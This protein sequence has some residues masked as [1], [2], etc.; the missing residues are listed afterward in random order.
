MITYTCYIDGSYIS[1]INNKIGYSYLI[2]KDGLIIDIMVDSFISQVKLN[3]S[4]AEL[5]GLLFSM[6]NIFQNYCNYKIKVF[7]DSKY[8]VDVFNNYKNAHVYLETWKYIF[9][10]KKT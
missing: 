3:S 9:Q 7:M 10:L 2:V 5:M 6:Y 4:L 8:V 1:S